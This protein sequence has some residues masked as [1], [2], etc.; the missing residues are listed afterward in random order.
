MTINYSDL[1]KK[2]KSIYQKQQ[3]IVISLSVLAGTI[4]LFIINH[5]MT[6]I[7]FN[8]LYFPF[9]FNISIILLFMALV[10]FLSSTFILGGLIGLV[11]IEELKLYTSIDIECTENRLEKLYQKLDEMEK[12]KD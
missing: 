9:G 7:G 5:V 10:A 8:L 6:T 2:E 11:I 3:F 1:S 12:S 4:S